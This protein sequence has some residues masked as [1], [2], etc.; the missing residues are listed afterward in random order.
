[1]PLRNGQ[2]FP[3]IESRDTEDRVLRVPEDLAG[4]WAV[5]LFYR[6]HW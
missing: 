3:A 6:G 4:S 5:L 1:M 2:T